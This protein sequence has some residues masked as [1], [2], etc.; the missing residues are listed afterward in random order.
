MRITASFP[1]GDTHY[2]VI[3]GIK[4]FGR[5]QI[6]GMDFHTDPRFES[7]NSSGYKYD[8]ETGTLFLKMR[9]KAENEDVVI[10]FSPAGSA[11]DNA[12]SPADSAAPADD[13]SNADSAS[14]GTG[15]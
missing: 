8:A 4:P 11:S 1:Q 7:Y 9:H 2:M 10:W 6:Y 13:G 15:Y 12:A 3:K 14:A 5:I